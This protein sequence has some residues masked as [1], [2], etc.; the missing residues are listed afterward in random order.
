M[1]LSRALS[2]PVALA[3][4]AL[5][6][7]SDPTPAPTTIT[8]EPGATASALVSAANGGSIAAGDL[9]L[10]IPPG[11]LAAD[12]TITVTQLGSATQATFSLQPAGTTFKT[13]AIAHYT[14]PPQVA[15][16]L[17]ATG[18][19]AGL[20]ILFDDD[21]TKAEY[22]PTEPDPDREHLRAPVEHF[23]AVSFQ[24]LSSET[25]GLEQLSPVAVAPA[26]GEEFAIVASYS[27]LA[28]D[29]A[30]ELRTHPD[31]LDP[32]ETKKLVMT[33][34]KLRFTNQLATAGPVSVIDT[35]PVQ[36]ALAVRTEAI[37]P[38]V[39][40]AK[41]DAF[42]RGAIFQCMGVGKGS[43][44]LFAGGVA[45]GTVV[46]PGLRLQRLPD[47]AG[48]Y[49]VKSATGQTTLNLE[50]SLVTP[51]ARVKADCTA[52]TAMM[53]SLGLLPDQRAKIPTRRVARTRR[54]YPD[55]TGKKQ[56]TPT[57]GTAIGAVQDPLFTVGP[58]AAA[59]W[60]AQF[61]C[62]DGPVGKT[63]CG[64]P[65]PFA[66]GDYVM[67]VSDFDA[68]LPLADPTWRYQHAF[69]FDADGIAG[70][71]YVPPAQYPKDFF[72]GSDKWFQLLYE[73][74]KGWSVKVVDAR[75]SNTNP[76]P[77]AA[78]FVIAGR[79]LAIFIP[80]SELNGAAPTFRA[81][82]FRHQGDYGLNGGP[83][84]LSYWPPLQEPLAPAVV[85]SAI[86][87]AE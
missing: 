12:T 53:S 11:A 35:S 79:E 50:L 2:I 41:G 25:I 15:A 9:V 71:D 67:L 54:S 14:M 19:V 3:I 68:D 39:E 77:S 43:G 60:T 26:V 6:C 16:S 69:V 82:T 23:S 5:A 32:I 63:V 36:G 48:R 4:A 21:G 78:R 76:V 46:V 27:A 31:G 87:V 47:A 61:P 70:N 42:Q 84:D 59:K 51:D 49:V 64:T 66:P 24:V 62:G 45:S 85:T 30:L 57:S 29:V 56:V 65:G 52:K 28:D 80:R 55:S 17:P 10:E 44:F 7:G 81:T 22:A 40:L 72:A 34:A 20:R 37:T 13:A 58:N 86:V 74:G 75:I 18:S 8:L 1:H 38:P 33:G 83:I 73:P